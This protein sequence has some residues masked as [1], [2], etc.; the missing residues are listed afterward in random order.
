MN[1]E[2]YNPSDANKINRTYLD[3]IQIEMRILDAVKA[4]I[5]F[6]FCGR[7]FSSPIMTPAFSHLHKEGADGLSQMEEYAAA[8]SRLNIANFVGM[9]PDGMFEKVSTVCPGTIRIIKP[10][11]DH[12]LILK[13]I[14]FA[15]EQGAIAVGMDIDHVFGKDGEYDIVDGITMGPVTTEDLKE[16]I[17]YAKLP[18]I[19]K[20]VL[21][22]T[23]ALKS[24]EA[25]ASA[26]LVSHHHGRVPFGIPPV[27]VLPK[28]REAVGNEM[29]I[30]VDCGIDDGYDAFKALALGADAVCVGRGILNPLVQNGTEGVIAKISEMNAQLMELMEYTNAHKLDEIDSSVIYLS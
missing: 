12:Q 27:K 22:V 24:K 5:S 17:A 23:D 28:I 15:R 16:Y 30:I 9:E 19:V 21:S 10:Y 20:G 18:F 26:I 7:E 14:D 1:S 25:G 2:T 29:T 6:S 4:D 11:A 8:A 3:S 13:E